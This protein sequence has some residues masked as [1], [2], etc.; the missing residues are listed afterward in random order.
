MLGYI[1][2]A[3]IKVIDNIISTAKNICQ[4]KE[5]K[6]LSS[7]LTI[8]S[9][10]IFYLV[11][12][13]VIE[14]NTII[15]IIIVSVASGLGNLIAFLLN[16]KFKRDT[17]WVML[18]TSNDINK[19]KDFSDYLTK[20]KIKNVVNRGYS[21]SWEDVINIIIFSKNKAESR[22]ITKYLEDNNFKYLLEI[23]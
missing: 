21:R 18:F 5:M 19:S 14:D 1:F 20:N 3:F 6:V 16:D 2:L 4:Y 11:I 9:Q 7:I 12:S 13:Q 17:K 23:I 22:L 15:S 8:V 10:L